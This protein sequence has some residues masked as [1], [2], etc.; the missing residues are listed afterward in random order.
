MKILKKQFDS[1]VAEAIE[2]TPKRLAK[3][4]RDLVFVVDD[5]PTR[6]VI[7]ESKLRRG[8]SLFGYY[9]GFEKTDSKSLSGSPDKIYVY[10]KHILDQ[11][12][13]QKTIRRQVMKTVWHEISH[14]FGS[15]EDGALRAEKMMFEKYVKKNQKSR[16]LKREVKKM[17]RVKKGRRGY[18]RKN[19]ITFRINEEA[20]F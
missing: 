18:K 2:M 4:M 20:I 17:S 12:K 6:E 13:T 14:H 7:R 16:H 1:W 5:C 3:G 19:K 11:Y 9:Q 10:R 8:Y 15:D